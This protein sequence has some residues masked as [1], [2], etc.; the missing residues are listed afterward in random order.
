MNPNYAELYAITPHYMQ[1]PHDVRRLLK[2]LLL[3]TSNVVK[4]PNG[5][6]IIKHK[7]K[8]SFT[9]FTVVSTRD[10]QTT[11]ISYNGDLIAQLNY[12]LQNLLGYPLPMY[13]NRFNITNS[14]ELTFKLRDY[15][16]QSTQPNLL[17]CLPTEVR[18][19][20]LEYLPNEFVSS[21]SISMD[22]DKSYLKVLAINRGLN[23]TLIERSKSSRRRRIPANIIR[24]WNE[25]R[26]RDK[27]ILKEDT[28]NP[29]SS[30][31]LYVDD[32]IRVI[33]YNIYVD[34]TFVI[35]RDCVGYFFISTPRSLTKQRNIVKT[36]FNK[37]LFNDL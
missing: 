29:Y 9:N 14:V 21:A 30:Y 7:D 25:L 37:D 24:M 5:N 28:S 27:F 13:S 36:V 1:I 6:Y 11:V 26:Q 34:L 10:N 8:I 22:V 20:I 4:L 16:Q 18:I 32:I 35:L 23:Y 17:T 2:E 12:A 19:G 31:K 15:Q 3:T 33:P